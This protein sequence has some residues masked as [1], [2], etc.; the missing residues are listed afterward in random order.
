MPGAEKSHRNHIRP[1]K[2]EK[3]KNV[4]EKKKKKKTSAIANF[5]EKMK[6]N[7]VR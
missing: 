5:I 4:K 3:K 7:L 6:T 1:E 2:T